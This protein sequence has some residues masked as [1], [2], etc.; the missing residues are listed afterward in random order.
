M[1]W[2]YHLGMLES[3]LLDRSL[4]YSD[5]GTSPIG[6]FTDRPAVGACIGLICKHAQ[7][8]S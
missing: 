4:E 3:C 7:Y 2:Y 5:S 1:Q 6:I 8:M